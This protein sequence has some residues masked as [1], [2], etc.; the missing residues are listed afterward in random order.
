M[1]AGPRKKPLHPLA[2]SSHKTQPRSNA[3]TSSTSA[4]TQTRRSSSYEPFALDAGQRRLKILDYKGRVR[5][6][7]SEWER[8]LAAF[9]DPN[10]PPFVDE[11]DA[12]DLALY[13]DEWGF[14][15]REA[16]IKGVKGVFMSLCG[17]K[18]ASDFE[19]KYA[20]PWRKAGR[21]GREEM[22]LKALEHG[23]R[24]SAKGPERAETLRMLAPEIT[25]EQMAGGE[26]EGFLKLIDALLVE[27]ST[28][29]G[30]WIV[31]VRQEGFERKFLFNFDQDT[32]LPASKALRGFQ[33]EQVLTRTSYLLVLV[34][35]VLSLISGDEFEKRS[36]ASYCLREYSAKNNQAAVAREGCLPELAEDEPIEKR[37]TGCGKTAAEIK[38]KKMLSCNKCRKVG[39]YVP[40]CSSQCMNDNFKLGVEHKK[41]CGQTLK[42]ATAVP[43]FSSTNPSIRL[44]AH[45]QLQLRGYQAF[46]A[47]AQAIWFFCR[48]LSRK[49]VIYQTPLVVRSPKTDSEAT[50]Q[51]Q[52]ERMM[53]IRDSAIHQRDDKSLGILLGYLL[54]CPDLLWSQEYMPWIREDRKGKRDL[55]KTE[56]AALSEVKTEAVRRHLMKS[57]ELKTARVEEL[58]ETGWKSLKEPGREVERTVW[59]NARKYRENSKLCQ[60]LLNFK[61]VS[62]SSIVD[63]TASSSPD[64]SESS[65]DWLASLL[66][67]CFLVLG[68][69]VSPIL[70][71]DDS[72]LESSDEED[73]D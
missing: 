10:S 54:E 55:T 63:V 71:D 16:G 60:E 43:T 64:S 37:C 30:E 38:P 26:G 42:D 50:R 46:N 28:E 29:D 21:E 13:V 51:Q 44:N 22:L 7:N 20:E 70:H 36:S 67:W 34:L 31:F 1:A 9:Y 65:R 68:L 2:P 5:D 39:R 52:T 11:E 14:H 62:N 17:E 53:A 33:Y 19:E 61:H 4:Q 59:T 15:C 56:Q 18:A 73:S 45:L 40:W 48:R 35:D 27:G 58:I 47:E 32:L 3:S 72:E 49:G 6:W 8:R 24:Q 69:F 23:H 57:F 41:T 25:L 12:A 66:F